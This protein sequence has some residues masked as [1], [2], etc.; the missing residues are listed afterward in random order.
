MK[1]NPLL[2][3]L[4]LLLCSVSLSAQIR[5]TGKVEDSAGPL[6]GVTVSTENNGTIQGVSTDSQG[7]YEISVQSEQATL[8]FSMIG[9][10]EH[11][12]TVGKRSIINVLMETADD[13]VIDESVVVGF[14]TQKKSN[15]TGAVSEVKMAD[16]LGDRPLPSVT[17]ALQG[18]VP[19]LTATGGHGPAS[20]MSL[21]I[22]GFTSTSG[23]SPLIL[24]DNVE[25]SLALINPQDIESISVLKDAAASS[26]YGARASFGVVLITTKKGKRNEKTKINYNNNF[27][28]ASPTL[29]PVKASNIETLTAIMENNNTDRHGWQNQDINRWIQFI[30]LYNDDPSDPMFRNMYECG[31]WKDPESPDNKPVFFYLKPV[32]QPGEIYKTGFSQTHNVSVS[33]GS[34]NTNYRISASSFSNNGILLGDRESY[35]RYTVSSYVNTSITKWLSQSLDL[36]LTSSNLVEPP[37]DNFNMG[38]MY[39]AVSNLDPV[40]FIPTTDAQGN[41]TLLPNTANAI[42]RLMMATP[43]VTKKIYPRLTARTVLN[44][45]KNLEAIFE[46]TYNFTGTDYTTYEKMVLWGRTQGASTMLGPTESSYTEKITKHSYNAI[47]AYLSYKL[48]LGENHLKFL[49]GYNNEKSLTTSVR[50]QSW[51]LVNPDKPSFT[52]ATGITADGTPH[53]SVV[54]D[55]FGEYRVMGA[56]F[57]V[58]YDYKN[59]YLLEVNGR[60][61]GSSKFPKVNRFGF[62]PSVSVG[63]N[64]AKE[65]FFENVKFI[66]LL[67]IRAS[68]GSIGNQNI[69]NYSYFSTVAMDSANDT[70]RN[71]YDV[72]SSMYPYTIKNSPNL[73][74]DN[75]TWE[76]VTTTNVGLDLGAFDNRLSA[77]FDI[78]ERITSDMLT[79]GM[80]LP[81]IVGTGSPTQNAATARTS[82]FELAIGWKDKIGKVFYEINGNVY[83]SNAVITKFNNPSKLLSDYYEGQ[84]IGEIWGYVTDGFYTADDFV[85]PSNPSAGLKEGVVTFKGNTNISPGDIKYKAIDSPERNPNYEEG[86]ITSG[87]DSALN[88]GDRK[89]IGYDVDHFNFGLNGRVAYA[90]FDFSF[91]LQGVGHHD[92]WLPRLFPFDGGDGLTVDHLNYWSP[93]NPAEGDYSA[94]N[95]NA[96]FPRVYGGGNSS[97]N[98]KVQTKYLANSAYIRVKNIT[99]SYSIPQAFLSRFKVS[100]LKFFTS[101]ENPFTITG[102]PNGYDPENAGLGDI[103]QVFKSVSFGVNLTL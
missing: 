56:F 66:D 13:M 71:W 89:I 78:Y 53:P 17:A 2:L 79:P 96:W 4:L 36:K 37:T 91:L 74:R 100:S 93:K 49:A 21:N 9:Y 8:R 52:T 35:N 94:A 62:F 81:S 11:L 83:N 50:S 73:I 47:N 7:N 80:T 77:N 12:E 69:G 98:A 15:L 3:T 85:N 54:E 75:F 97:M 27:S 87:D 55:S 16:V 64:I 92:V 84:V 28:F 22:R 31:A 33:G 26:I 41:I 20:N 101:I 103:Y 95:P 19:G 67:K 14:S 60:Y 63:W 32:M 70:K 40:G 82:G 51:G 5:V 76:T 46:Y 90:G 58:N 29:L 102:L 30:K 43:S 23:G 18:A 86:V 1:A 10:N 99:L 6:V 25:A 59:K 48:D 39:G 34:Q 45:V 57:R 38:R 88:P 68:Y 72:N 42:S 44:P 65:G 24:I 61:D